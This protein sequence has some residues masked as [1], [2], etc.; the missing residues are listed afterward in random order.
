M[1]VL[2]SLT[3][4]TTGSLCSV[5]LKV[6][7]GAIRDDS[8]SRYKISNRTQLLDSINHHHGRKTSVRK[9]PSQYRESPQAKRYKTGIR[10]LLL[11][12]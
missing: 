2:R 10:L 7:H 3:D 8:L 9:D 4:G 6:R 5:M 1:K 11:E 12:I